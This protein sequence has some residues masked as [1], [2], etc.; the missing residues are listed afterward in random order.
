MNCSRISTFAVTSSARSNPA[1]TTINREYTLA[2][3]APFT[4]T[5]PGY[6]GIVG[7]TDDNPLGHPLT[8]YNRTKTAAAADQF[9]TYSPGAGNMYRTW[10]VE[11]VKRMSHHFLVVTGADW[12]K[13]DFGASVFSNNANTIIGQ[14]LY[15]SSHYWDWTG[16]LTLQYEA[17]RGIQ[18]SSVFKS[19]K[20]AASTR[21][22][23]V[24]CD[25]PVAAFN[26]ATTTNAAACTAAG[27]KAPLQSAFD[28]TVEQSGSG[29][30]NFLPT[31]STLDLSV[32][33]TFKVTEKQKLQAMFDLFN[34]NN[35]NA[36]QGWGTTSATTNF[37]Y[38]GQSVTNYPTYHRPSS[39]LPPR[40]FR[41][42]ARYSF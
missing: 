24:F 19:Q 32:V 27:G 18:V 15:P 1:V 10:E 25:R 29:K 5:D 22:V 39:T 28:L 36:L 42:S 33:K 23:N 41:L 12:T 13:L 6:D 4:F 14:T 37:T 3:W 21:T 16:K 34:I 20:G 17:P 7:T 40:I 11:G 2:D 38:N 26:P 35:S 9:I 30:A 8:A 31:L